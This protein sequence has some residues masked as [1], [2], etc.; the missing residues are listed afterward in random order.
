MVG[1]LT[2]SLIH[3]SVYPFI[4]P[5]TSK[6][7]RTAL[8]KA[9]RELFHGK[10]DSETDSTG[11]ASDEG[12][13]IVIKWGRKGSG[14]GGNGRGVEPGNAAICCCGP[15]VYPHLAGKGRTPRGVYPPY[16]HFTLQK[17]NRDT[18]DALGHLSR[19]LHVSIKDL[20]VA[21]TKDKRGV[22][23]QRVSLKRNNK[24]VEDVWKLANGIDSR[25]PAREVLTKRGDRG[26]RIADLNYRKASLELGMLKGNAFVITLRC[27][28]IPDCSILHCLNIALL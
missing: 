9:I 11:P 4:Q 7:T 21:G 15:K 19:L 26:V 8:H 12:S 2:P 25:K 18:Q 24:T 13:R 5:I 27:V 23:V 14:R 10:L 16:I 17:T 3:F 22:T 28:G 1:P 6:V 20:S